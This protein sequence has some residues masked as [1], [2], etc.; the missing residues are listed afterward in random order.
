[1]PQGAVHC[2]LEQDIAAQF[3]KCGGFWCS[4][5]SAAYERLTPEQPLSVIRQTP[6]Q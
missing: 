2:R 5:G 4:E 1:M 6:L 3:D